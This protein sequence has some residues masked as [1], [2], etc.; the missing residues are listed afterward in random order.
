MGVRP[1]RMRIVFLCDEY[2]PDP[3]GGLGTFVQTM[4]HALMAEGHEVT[5]VGFSIQRGSEMDGMVRVVRLRPFRIPGVS[6]LLNRVRLRAW[7][8]REL[9]ERGVDVVEAPEFLG[10][11]PWQMPIPVIVR[12]HLSFTLISDA[13]G[14]RAPLAVRALERA[15][16]S[17]HPDWIAVSRHALDLT[18]RTFGVRPQRCATIYTPIPP[19]DPGA[20]G[21]DVGRPFVLFAGTVSE[22]KGAID[23]ALAARTFLASCPDASLVFAG[24]HLEHAGR[25]ISEA[26]LELLAEHRARVLFTGPL[27]RDEVRELMSR[28]SVFA[29][30]ST[31]ETFG[32]VVAEA[33]REGCPVVVPR[34]PPFDEFV[35]DGETGITVPPQDTAALASAIELLLRDSA[36]ASRIGSAGRRFVEERFDVGTAVRETLSFYRS[37]IASPSR[38]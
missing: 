35:A 1:N 31:L 26:I 34:G 16:L 18:T 7:L 12:L 32:L 6:W 3:G 30:P 28:A 21:P 20:T 5:S 29:Y 9:A 24:R 11:V 2:P 4:S 19:R 22:R 15:T 14:Q 33:M 38:T 10:M 23:L 8:E 36:M 13:A 27:P 37:V 25:S 17:S